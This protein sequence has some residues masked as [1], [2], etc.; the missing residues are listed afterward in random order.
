MARPRDGNKRARGLDGISVE[1]FARLEC[2]ATRTE[3][4]GDAD[5][6]SVAV[7][8][9]AKLGMGQ[10]ASQWAGQS[11][12]ARTCSKLLIDDLPYNADDLYLYRV[13]SP[14]GAI[15]GVRAAL[16]ED[17]SCSGH[18]YVKFTEPGDASR[19]P[20]CAQWLTTA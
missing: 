9:V 17:G 16:N 4:A 10:M 1:H 6:V 15:L 14:F 11:L 8:A 5:V 12:G 20:C 13:F 2:G 7:E 3:A 19:A 18:G